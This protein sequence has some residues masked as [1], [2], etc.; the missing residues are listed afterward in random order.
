M[1]YAFKLVRNSITGK[2]SKV[3]LKDYEK[4]LRDNKIE[5]D[6]KYPDKD[7]YVFVTATFNGLIYDKGNYLS[8]PMRFD[9]I[10]RWFNQDQ[11]LAEMLKLKSSKAMNHITKRP[12]GFPSYNA[13]LETIK[14][15]P[16]FKKPWFESKRFVT[17]INGF[18]ERPNLDHAPKEFKGK[19]YDVNLVEPKFAAGLYDIW[20]NGKESLTSASIITTDSK[21]NRKIEN[22]YHERCPI[23]LDWDQVEEWLDIKTPLNRIY[24]MCKVVKE[25]WIDIQEAVKD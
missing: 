20:N 21:G 16:T 22:I 10:P 23:I 11:T 12:F 13:R 7:R 4:L 3:R 18:R 8:T 19:E 1:C 15:K 9:M 2:V 14:E 5:W 17:L 24:E 6:P 25:D